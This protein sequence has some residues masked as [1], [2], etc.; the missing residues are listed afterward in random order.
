MKIVLLNTFDVRGGAAVAACRLNTGLRSIGID[1]RML[2][3]EKAGDDPFVTGPATPL[4]R[5]LSAF[6]PMFDSLPLRCYPERQRITFSSAILPDRISREIKKMSPSIVHLHWIAA[7]FLRI[8][9][10][11]MLGRPLVWTL[12]DSWAFTGGC[13]LPFDCLRYREACGVCPTLGSSRQGDLSRWI[14]KRKKKAW[15]NLNLT[16]IAPSRWLARCAGAS[17]LF[18][19][20]RIEIIPNGLDMDR[21]RP[22][23]QGT[24]RDILSLPRH[25]KLI[26]F[27]GAQASSDP[28]KGF[29][30]LTEALGILSSRGWGDKADVLVFGSHQPEKDLGFGMQGHYLGHVHDDVTLSLLYSAADV[31]VAPSIQENLPNTVMEAAACGTPSVAFKIGGLPDLVEHGRTGYL[32][33]PFDTDD[34]A[35][36]IAVLLEDDK[37]RTEMG[38]AA[39]HKVISEFALER[40]AR[41]HAEIYRGILIE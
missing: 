5:A 22:I 35:Q 28:N 14:W 12:H 3:Q 10:L 11:A 1:S 40:I 7:G 27:G 9:T 36:G 33:Q 8:E 32:A 15:E 26:L 41:R 6:R 29:H 2:V 13:H 31:F 25:R 4:R 21:F 18:R 19:N 30:Y 17:S 39:R 20:T 38:D 34:L 24:A 37:K 16:V 23:D